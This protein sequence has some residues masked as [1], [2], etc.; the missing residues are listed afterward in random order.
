LK[1]KVIVVLPLLKKNEFAGRLFTIKSLASTVGG[2]APPLTL[3]IK[4]VGGTKTVPPQ[5]ELVT[6]Q[7][8]GVGVGVGAPDC[9]QYL[10]P[11]LR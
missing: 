9:V 3:I 10:P 5:T 7:D 8:M 6:E 2:S 1:W 4:S 11:L